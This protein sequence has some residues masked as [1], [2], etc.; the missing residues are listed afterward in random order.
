MFDFLFNR[1]KEVPKFNQYYPTL[2]GASQDQRR[3]FNWFI[4]ELEKGKTPD[5]Q[6]NLSYV[7]LVLYITINRFIKDRNYDQLSDNFEALKPYI[8]EYDTIEKYA[9]QWHR[10]AALL[11]GNWQEVWEHGRKCKLNT[12]IVSHCISK[13]PS[14]KIVAN[15]LYSFLDNN[16]GLTNYGSDNINSV[17]KIAD[18]ILN[19]HRQVE[20]VN[21][22]SSLRNK[23][24]W[25]S[26]S[27]DQVLEIADECEYLYSIRK[28][29][30]AL[31]KVGNHSTKTYT[32]F[33]SVPMDMVHSTE[34]S[35][36]DGLS[37][38]I[39]TSVRADKPQVELKTVNPVLD[40]VILAK[41][42]SI[43]RE[44]E[45]LL[46]EKRELPRIGEGWISETKLYQEIKNHF[47]DTAVVQHARPEWLK[48]QHL[49]V[50]LPLHKVAIEFQG[51]QHI[52]PVDYFGG[53]KAF[54]KQQKR[55]ARKARLC[56]E[57]NCELIE[58]FQ[59]YEP[60]KVLKKISSAIN[61]N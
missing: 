20:R 35:N 15:D 27:E 49:D 18:D 12:T 31:T 8:Y 38:E 56:E 40:L 41:S 55:D 24:D 50:F 7:F 59:G 48:P 57:N 39:E 4:K 46:R 34:K 5:I 44:A 21:F 42:K 19:E 3:Y 16:P 14:I 17:N 13:E 25:Q 29:K 28:F 36:F 47:E 61:E 60:K 10:D 2:E 43:L 22:L 30:N 37:F 32:L 53:E 23:Y 51:A 26:L 6:G 54:K 1:F 52:R 11:A 58:V 45:N 9:H 33:Q